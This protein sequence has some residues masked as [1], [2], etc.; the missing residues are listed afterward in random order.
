MGYLFLS[1]A[2]FAGTAK[3][4]CGKK[5]SNLADNLQSAAQLNLIRMALCIAFGAYDGD[6][7]KEKLT[8]KCL[9]GIFLA[10]WGLLFMNVLKF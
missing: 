4:Y 8:L 1:I 9:I 3:G 6:I 5:M 7:L 10:F 2:L